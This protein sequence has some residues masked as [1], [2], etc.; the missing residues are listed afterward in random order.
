MLNVAGPTARR[1]FRQTGFYPL[2]IQCTLTNIKSICFCVNKRPSLLYSARPSTHSSH[3]NMVVF[4]S[5][6]CKILFLLQSITIFFDWTC[7]KTRKKNCFEF[8]TNFRKFLSSLQPSKNWF[9]SI[10]SS[11]KDQHPDEW[12]ITVKCKL[13]EIIWIVN[14]K[15]ENMFVM[16]CMAK[17]INGSYLLNWYSCHHVKIRKGMVL[18]WIWNILIS[19]RTKKNVLYHPTL[20]IFNLRI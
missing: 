8:R 6:L 7:F 15:R 13:L 12:E 16:T 18:F 3:S 20:Y 9:T 2:V 17:F 14:W 10:T 4:Q 5:S 11:T 19:M 1:K